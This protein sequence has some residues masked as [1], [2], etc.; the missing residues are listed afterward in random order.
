MSS[1]LEAVPSGPLS[2]D[3]GLSRGTPLDRRYIEE[4][5]SKHRDVIRGNVLELEDST[6]TERFGD[7]SGSEVLDIDQ[8]NSH[9]TLIADLTQP[10]SLPVSAY[11]CIILTQTL[12]LL[13]EPAVCIENCNAALKPEGSLLLTAPALSRISPTYPNADFWRFTPNGIRQLFEKHWTGPFTV[14]S[15]GNL[16]ICIGFLI[17]RTV[18][19]T[20]QDAFIVNDPRFPLTVAVHAENR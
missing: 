14:S 17:A 12:H 11:D 5:L 4:F 20:P 16:R 10:G 9:A 6:Y 13:S 19:E 1:W 7:A 18:E 15:F 3:H 2:D 8:A